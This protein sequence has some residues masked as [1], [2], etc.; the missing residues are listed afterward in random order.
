MLRSI[1]LLGGLFGLTLPAPAQ[2][3]VQARMRFPGGEFHR[4]PEE[5]DEYLADQAGVHGHGGQVDL[6]SVPAL[7]LSGFIDAGLPTGKNKGTDTLNVLYTGK[8][9]KIVHSAATQNPDSGLV[10]LDYGTAFFS[11]QYASMEVVTIS[12]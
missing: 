3:D 1:I 8:R 4:V 9:P 6:G 11:I 12:K 5:V 10:T 2:I 7:T